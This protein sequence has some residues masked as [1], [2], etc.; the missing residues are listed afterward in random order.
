M[1]YLNLLIHTTGSHGSDICLHLTANEY[2]WFHDI[3]ERPVDLSSIKLYEVDVSEELLVLQPAP[4]LFTLS[5]FTFSL[6]LS[7]FPD[8][9]VPLVEFL[10]SACNARQAFETFCAISI[11]AN[12]AMR[13]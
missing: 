8:F 13:C 1:D 9:V 10:H 11:A 3:V 2:N 4:P 12:P 5:E 7:L 6:L